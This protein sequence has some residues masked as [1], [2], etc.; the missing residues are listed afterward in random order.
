MSV[1]ELLLK[2]QRQVVIIYL[3]LSTCIYIRT[4]FG[5]LLIVNSGFI[6]K[7]WTSIVEIIRHTS[8]YITQAKEKQKC[9]QIV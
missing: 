5:K 6:Q 3:N 4:Q 9:M 8:D 2:S 1:H 7:A